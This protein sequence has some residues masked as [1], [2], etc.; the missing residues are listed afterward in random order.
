[1]KRLISSWCI[2]ACL[3]SCDVRLNEF[4]EPKTLIPKG[5]MAIIIEDIM[6]VEHHVQSRFPRP[7]QFQECV[8]KSGDT[9]L[10]HN[11]VS[12]E[13]F[14]ASLEYYISKQ[15]EMQEI[16]DVVLHSVKK[17]LDALKEKK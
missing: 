17:K 9:I 1:M 8:S 16:Y 4:E 10:A 11:K 3:L 15:D 12:F 13:R 7:D 2:A 5:K 6:V 14:N